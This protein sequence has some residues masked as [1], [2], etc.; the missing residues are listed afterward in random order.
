[1]NTDTTRHEPSDSDLHAYVDGRLG[2]ARRAAVEAWLEAHPKRAR[3]VNGWKRDAEHLRAMH[4]HPECWTPN[5]TLDPAHMRQRLRTRRHRRLSMAASLLL[6]FVIGGGAGWQARELRPV[7][8]HLPMADA[9]AAYRQFAEASAPQMEFDA[10]RADDLQRWLQRH[11]GEA[12][13]VPDLRAAGYRLMGGRLLSTEQGAAALLVYQD[14]SGARIGFYLRPRG[15][16]RGNG[17]RLDGDLLAQYWSHRNTGYAIVSEATDAA[18]LK[19]PH[20]LDN[21]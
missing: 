2:P 19:L 12:E 13:R 6:A 11:F 10:S 5:A 9:V 8:P 3:Q 1:M 7:Q 15:Q 14:G 17:R 21:G 18:A 16:L 4:A 20:L